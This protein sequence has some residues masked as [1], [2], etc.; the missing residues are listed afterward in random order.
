MHSESHERSHKCDTASLQR[1]LRKQS[2]LFGVLPCLAVIIRK[3]RN[4]LITSGP[5][6]GE[7]SSNLEEYMF[8][9]VFHGLYDSPKYSQAKNRIKCLMETHGRGRE[10]GNEYVVNKRDN[11][12]KNSFPL[13]LVLI[14]NIVI[15]GY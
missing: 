14:L 5:V 12:N 10:K 8:P 7:E 1:Q 15:Y 11:F 3:L 9:G 6:Q 2:S 13:K 4:S